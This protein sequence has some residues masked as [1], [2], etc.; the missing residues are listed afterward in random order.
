MVLFTVFPQPETTVSPYRFPKL[1]RGPLKRHRLK[2]TK[3]RFT[4]SAPCFNC[5][6]SIKALDTAEANCS[7]PR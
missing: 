2:L 4:N 5:H 3:S 6:L 1:S 7:L